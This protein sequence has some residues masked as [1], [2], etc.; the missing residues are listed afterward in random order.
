MNTLKLATY[1][2]N[3]IRT[4]LP[5]LLQWLAKDRPD[6]VC[7]QELKAEDHSFPV[8]DLRAAGYGAVWHGQKSWNG[9]AILARGATPVEP[10]RGLAGDPSDTQSRYIEAVAHGIVVGCLYLPNGNPQPG[11]KYDYK[12]QWM[13]RLIAHAAGLSRGG[14]PAAIVGDFNVIP[15]DLD[16][17]NPKSWEKDALMQPAVRERY[18]RL[19]AQGWT[20]ALRRRHP[21]GPIYTFWDYFRQH[22][23]RDAGL[24]IDH[25]LLN[26]ELAPRLVD[27]GVD[28]I[29]CSQRRIW[30][31]EFPEIDG[32]KGLNFAGWAKKL[33]GLP[34]ISVGS[35]GL[36][37]EFTGAFRGEGSK[38]GNFDNAIERL[39]KG[40][41]DLVAVGR[42]LLQDPDWVLKVKASKFDDLRDYD[43]GA[44]KVYY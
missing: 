30:E 7:L 28:M 3:G 37:S 19:L 17:Y 39:D 43:A 44:L 16:V 23:Q 4:R 25:L 6:I 31:A 1:N 38:A 27:A 36:T 41:Y 32:E 8:A 40:E 20:D 34:T 26:P 29:H 10:R 24:R 5:V 35:V 42:A 33:T 12:L 11:P 18:E 21:E 15:T 9:V 13:D 2:I 22:W 14:V